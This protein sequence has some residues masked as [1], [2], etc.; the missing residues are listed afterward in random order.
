MA[1][2]IN[3][4]AKWHAEIMEEFERDHLDRSDKAA[5]ARF[6]RL[7]KT[8]TKYDVFLI[9]EVYKLPRKQSEQ[10]VNDLMVGRCLADP[11]KFGVFP[12][13]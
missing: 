1:Q 9:S 5:V 3:D 12:Y 4:A 13:K 6:E 11:A 2:A 7:K 8:G 10:D